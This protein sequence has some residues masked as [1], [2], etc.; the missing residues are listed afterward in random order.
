MLIYYSSLYRYKKTNGVQGKNKL[1]RNCNTSCSPEG[2]TC[3]KLKFY[4]FSVLVT[5]ILQELV[6]VVFII[7][8]KDIVSY[9]LVNTEV[10]W[11]DG[12]IQA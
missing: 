11:V 2:A 9:S 10:V 12:R 1:Q 7:G 6:S 3:F 5:V 4:F 8:I